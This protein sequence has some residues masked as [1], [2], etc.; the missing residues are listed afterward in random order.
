MT[1]DNR[2]HSIWRTL[3]SGESA[4]FVMPIRRSAQREA[5]GLVTASS[6]QGSGALFANIA[7]YRTGGPGWTIWTDNA[8][9]APNAADHKG[10]PVDEP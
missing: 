7:C 10:T 2:R 9:D 4:F 6:P 8:I 1:A 3:L 5:S